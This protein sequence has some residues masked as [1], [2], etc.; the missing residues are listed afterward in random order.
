MPRALVTGG[1]G[2]IGS[3][4]VDALLAA[5]WQVRVLDNLA[6]GRREQVPDEAEFFE[7]NVGDS[8]L[9]Q[10]AC[11]AVD[12][13]FH[14]AAR[15]S[16]RDSFD[17]MVEHNTTNV[18]GTLVMLKAAAAA[19]VTRFVL[20]SSMAVYADAEP[21]TA[22]AESHPTRPLSPYGISKLAAEEFVLLAAPAFGVEPVV[23]R[24]FN[25]YGPRQAFSPY[26]GVVTIFIT[27]L[28]QGLPCTI[29]GEGEQCRDFVHVSDV[30]RA[31]LAAGHESA[32][33]GQCIN[34][35]SGRGTTVNELAMLIAKA[36]VT[37]PN[38]TH[39]PEQ[40]GELRNSVADL[41][42]ARQLLKY[43]PAAVL[44]ERLAQLVAEFRLR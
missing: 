3:H 6:T 11:Q 24:F 14:L 25:T 17:F 5:G 41:T 2:F 10:Q 29:Y 1:A 34:V 19:G 27:R 30:V 23:L 12:V 31:C 39:G 37:T 35:G 16:V 9:A 28:L 7:G 43:A 44:E 20:A 18:T 40:S 4:L 33:V 32:A 15:V 42:R 36:V 13:V 8:Q 21:G 38:F 22:N 26:V